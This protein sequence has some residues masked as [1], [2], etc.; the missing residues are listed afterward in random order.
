MV[1]AKADRQKDKTRK[2]KAKVIKVERNS[3]IGKLKM[4]MKGELIIIVLAPWCGACKVIKPEVLKSLNTPT[5]YSRALVDSEVAKNIP[6]LNNAVTRYPSFLVIKN[7]SPMDQT[8]PEG[9]TKEVQTSPKTAEEL[10]E[11]AN[12]P[13]SALA[14]PSQVDS[15]MTN[16]K[17]N[18]R[19]LNQSAV[20]NATP[21]N[22]PAQNNTSRLMNEPLSR[23]PV[24]K[25]EKEEKG[26]TPKYISDTK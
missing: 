3:D 17:R 15:L 21:L 11:L 26:F 22:L 8:G 12:N 9:I 18:T 20:K 5:K 19:R 24:K 13:P 23:E 4:A 7:G 1:K 14:S 16:K 25:V 6:A 2:A 10:V